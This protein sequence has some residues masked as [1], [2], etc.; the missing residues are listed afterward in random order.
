[1]TYDCEIS[2]KEY[3]TYQKL[4]KHNINKHTE[5]KQYNF[6]YELCNKK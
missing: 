3:N 5:Q 4:L 2:N 6:I 1:M